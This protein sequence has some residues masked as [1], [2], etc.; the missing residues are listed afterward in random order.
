MRATP[1]RMVG[2]RGPECLLHEAR[3]MRLA[4]LALPTLVLLSGC[5]D[6]VTVRVGLEPITFERDLKIGEVPPDVCPSV[7]R[8]FTPAS[9]LAGTATLAPVATSCVLTVRLE[10]AVLMDRATVLVIREELEGADTTAL[11][12]VVVQVNEVEVTDARGAPLDPRAIDELEVGIDG[13]P[14]I[15]PTTLGE[16]LDGMEVALPQRT[17]DELLAG[18]AERR[19][20]RADLELRLSFVDPNAIPPQ[21]RVRIVLTPILLVDAVRAAL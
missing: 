5:E 19:E 21:A 20:V 7:S 13:V 8:D 12:G 17:V 10:D 1:T 3:G 18:I 14:V 9:A 16:P 11:L 2:H 6:L 4:L 15:P